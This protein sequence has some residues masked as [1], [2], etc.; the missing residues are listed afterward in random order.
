MQWLADYL[1]AD[2]LVILDASAPAA[3]GAARAAYLTGHIPGA[4]FADIP[5][6]FA[7]PECE[8]GFARP[9]AARFQAAAESVGVSQHSTVIVYDNAGSQ[10]A[11]HLWW[12]FRSFGFDQV[13]VLDG[14]L[15]KWTLEHRTVDTGAMHPEPGTFTANERP[16]LWASADE[17]GKFAAGTIDGA[18][19]SVPAADRLVDPT[20]RA[21]VS[22]AALVNEF[23]PTVAATTSRLLVHDSGIAAAASA[24]ALTLAGH[25]DIAILES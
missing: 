4:V 23:G 3:P 1:G 19:L 8:L 10:L 7:D 6:L 17:R 2:N 15:T 20:T 22:R 11:A 12:L 24:L 25:T 16:E 18:L 14:G 9:S 21:F 5:A 13:A